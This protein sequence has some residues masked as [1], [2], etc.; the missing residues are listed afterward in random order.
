MKKIELKRISYRPDCALGVL[1]NSED[2]MP[3]CLTLED[4]DR[5]NQKGMSCIP[6]GAYYC[7]P[8]CSEKFQNVYE[9][10]GVPGRTSILIHAGNTSDDTSGCILPGLQYGILKSKPAVL[11]S[12]NAMSSLHQVTKHEPFMLVIS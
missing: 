10:N 6:K 12:K 1:I 3:I 5:N 9:V 8:Y 4:P 7:A 2:N 11:N